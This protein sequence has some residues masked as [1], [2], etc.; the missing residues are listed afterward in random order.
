MVAPQP[1]PPATTPQ[2]QSKPSMELKKKEESKFIGGAS[3]PMEIKKIVGP[4]SKIK[5][6]PD[7]KKEE[8]PKLKQPTNSLN[9]EGFSFTQKQ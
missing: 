6:P 5:P 9:M 3:G 2:L 7:Q 4:Q 1:K 8:S